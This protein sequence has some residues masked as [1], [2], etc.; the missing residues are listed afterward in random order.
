[1]KKSQALFTDAQCQ[2]KGQRAQIQRNLLPYLRTLLHCVADKALAQAAHRDCGV[3]S[4]EISKSSLERSL[5]TLL[6]QE[7][8]QVDPE[9]PYN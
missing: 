6:G 8:N 3:S 1:M 7:L 4:L 2:N 5:G 9:V